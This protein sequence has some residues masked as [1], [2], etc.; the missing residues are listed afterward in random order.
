MKV[1]FLAGINSVHTRKLVRALAERGIDI[2]LFSLTDVELPW[3]QDIKGLEVVLTGLVKKNT[4]SQKSD[5]LKLAYLKALPQ[6]AKAIK[7]Y[8]PDILHAHYATSYGLLG[9]MS[10]F[11]PFILSVWGSDIFTFP[12]KSFLHK[13]LLKYN[14]RKADILLSTSYIMAKETQKYVSTDISIIPFGV[15][16][17]TFKP[18][19][20]D[21]LFDKDDIVIGTIKLLEKHYGIDYLIRA[22]KILYD[23]YP[24]LPLKLLIVGD[25]SQWDFLKKLTKSLK[26]EQVTTFK[27]KVDYEEVYQYHNMITIFVNISINESF[28]VSV[29]EASACEKPV[30]V[31]DVGGL[32]EV[33]D[34][35]KT[36]IIVPAKN[37]E[38]TAEAIEK[39]ILNNDLSIQMGKAG[40]KK[41]EKQY[42]W[43]NCVGQIIDIYKKTISE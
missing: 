38:K 43:K 8:Q 24:K 6:V 9:A 18:K 30:V 37:A 28:G 35:N 33:T 42:D 7:Q 13:S 19:K 27:G 21:S 3:Y 32:P 15:D 41:V 39:L 16:L 1:L 10:G 20:I 31:S 36:G 14:L 12:R 23:K 22:F 11:H 5:I 25:G 29:L 2:C 26:V 40:R 34:D 4:H 17:E